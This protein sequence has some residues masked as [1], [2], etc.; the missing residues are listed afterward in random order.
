MLKQNAVA[1]SITMAFLRKA[2]ISTDSVI[3]KMSHDYNLLVR[4]IELKDKEIGIKSEENADCQ[5]DL[6]K[7]KF[8]KWVFIIAI[9]ISFEAGYKLGRK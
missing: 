5:G 7:N 8:L 9:P 3:S 2:H 4:K 6:K 1:D